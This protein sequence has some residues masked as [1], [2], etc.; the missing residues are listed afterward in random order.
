LAAPYNPQ[1]E[2]ISPTLPN[3]GL[4]DEIKQSKEETVTK[5]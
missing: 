2:A 4:R 5:Y 3:D 1:V